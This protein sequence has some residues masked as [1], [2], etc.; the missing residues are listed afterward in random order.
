MN[1]DYKQH[2]NNREGQMFLSDTSPIIG[3]QA[4]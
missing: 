3:M 4:N 2:L 1:D